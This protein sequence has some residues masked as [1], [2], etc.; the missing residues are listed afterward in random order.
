MDRFVEAV[1]KEDVPTILTLLSEDAIL[2]SDGGGKAT[3]ASHPIQTRDRIIR[4]LLG[5]TRKT[6]HSKAN[7]PWSEPHSMVRLVSSFATAL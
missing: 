3:A 7:S 4:F 2:I 6:V 1:V 5:L